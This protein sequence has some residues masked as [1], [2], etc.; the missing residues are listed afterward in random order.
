MAVR[1]L[2][3]SDVLLDVLTEDVGWLEWSSDAL[4][5]AA[6]AGPLYINPVIY[7]E[8]SVRFSLIED[9]DDA[10]P[11][12]DYRRLARVVDQADLHGGRS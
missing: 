5:S 1:A 11:P 4:A 8:V 10:L 7:A 6:E 12:S 3:D 2:V 9:V